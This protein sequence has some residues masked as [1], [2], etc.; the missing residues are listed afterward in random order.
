MAGI[1]LHIPFCKQAC[2]YCN[3]HFSTSMAYRAEVI[4]A[5]AKELDLQK[6]YLRGALVES[7]YLGG[8]TPSLLGPE[9]LALLFGQLEALYVIHPEAEITLEA[10]PDDLTEDR[11]A[12]LR[13]SP[14]NRLS[15][16][17]QSFADEDLVFMNRAHNA[18]EAGRCI[19]LAHRYGFDNLT[20]DLIY[21]TPTLSNEQWADNIKKVIDYQ[22]PHLSC[23]CLTVEPQT[24]LDHFV[25]T[26]KAKPVDDKKAEEQFIFLMEELAKAGYEH[27]EISNFARPGHYA[28]HNSAYWLGEPYLGVGPGAHSYNG[29]SRQW[30]I[31]HNGKYRQALAKDEVPYERE[32]L[33]ADQ[34]YNEYV[35]TRL[36]TRWGV[37]LTDLTEPYRDHFL[38]QIQT[39]E[40]GGQVIQERGR[41]LLTL[42]GKL[43]ADRIAMDL[44]F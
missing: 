2:H 20:V 37:V 36:R 42:S 29:E 17:I 13:D 24:A 16:G 7:V 3:F 40:K 4:A 33:S 25:K 8:G 35:L 34:R 14:V 5:I 6:D 9:E 41:Y 19:E 39:Y 26:G 44:F 15:I 1:Y 10:N 23:Y 21:G 32:L 30:N 22:V 31:A 27:Y 28:K 12:Q 38:K 11:L 18:K 43:L